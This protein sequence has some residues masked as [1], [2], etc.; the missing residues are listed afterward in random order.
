MYCHFSF[1]VSSEDFDLTM[2]VWLLRHIGR[3]N[4]GDSKPTP[5]D[6][7]LAADLSRLKYYRNV[8]V[9]LPDGIISDEDFEKYF[10]EICEVGF[11]DFY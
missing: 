9:H 11:V 7:S 6:K 1:Q 10:Y 5:G 3:L 2:M 8:I 4:I